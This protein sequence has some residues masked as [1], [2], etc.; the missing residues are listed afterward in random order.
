MG[1]NLDNKNLSLDGKTVITVEMQPLY[2]VLEG[3]KKERAE[4]REELIQCSESLKTCK[5]SEQRKKLCTERE[6]IQVDI[7]EVDEEIRKTTEFIDRLLVND[8]SGDLTVGDIKKLADI[9]E[10]TNT[11]NVSV[12]PIKK[13]NDGNSQNNQ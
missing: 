5:V 13:E 10:T 1:D 7:K 4:L 3:L 8:G 11:V 12:E 6:E 9:N 2:D